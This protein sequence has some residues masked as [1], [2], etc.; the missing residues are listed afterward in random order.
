MQAVLTTQ[1]SPIVNIIFSQKTA[2]FPEM[3]RAVADG[4]A[5]PGSDGDRGAKG[6]REA[7]PSWQ[8][9]ALL[10]E[11]GSMGLPAVMEVTFGS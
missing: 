1:S 7:V 2:R 6:I 11:C 9:P 5:S 3:P 4:D 10:A 8:L